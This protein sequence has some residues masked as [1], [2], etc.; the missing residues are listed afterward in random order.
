MPLGEQTTGDC[1]TKE[2][3]SP[4]DEI[5]FAVHFLVM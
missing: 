1:R 3:R 2:S 4:G 5:R